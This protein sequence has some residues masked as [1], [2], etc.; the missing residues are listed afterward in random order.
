[1]TYSTYYDSRRTDHS[2]AIGEIKR[3]LDQF[4]NL[5]KLDHAKNASV[6]IKQ[7]EDK[8]LTLIFGSDKF[9][10]VV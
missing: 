2:T 1:M 3:L 9:K 10:A 7:I 5:N 6:L 4:K 8:E